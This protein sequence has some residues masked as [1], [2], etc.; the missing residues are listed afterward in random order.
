LTK[1]KKVV[2]IKVGKIKKGLRRK[3][4]E[5]SITVEVK[6]NGMLRYGK[7]TTMADFTFKHIDDEGKWIRRAVG[8]GR[9]ADDITALGLK[10]GDIVVMSGYFKENTWNVDWD[11]KPP[12]EFIIR[13]IV[14]SEVT[15]E[16][17]KADLDKMMAE[18]AN[19]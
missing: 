14:L 13:H 8:F 1:R 10:E 19:Y 17:R 15:K 5:K 3:K 2:I 6:E 4:M 12:K 11:Q 7:K 16:K 9:V 18:A